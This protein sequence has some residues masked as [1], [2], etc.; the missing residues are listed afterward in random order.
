MTSKP[1]LATPDHSEINSNPERLMGDFKALIADAEALINATADR[2]GSPIDSIRS[3]ALETL[4]SA[5]ENL[6]S[7]EDAISDKAKVIAEGADEFVHR[8]PWEAVGVAA[9]LGLLIG[10][11]VSRR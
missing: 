3:K 8:K 6:L 2:E 1:H 10:L 7:V 5:K 11:L 4:A 9:G